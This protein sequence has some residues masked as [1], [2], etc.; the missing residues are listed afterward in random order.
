MIGIWPALPHVV[1]G[2]ARA[3]AGSAV[4]VH[5]GSHAVFGNSGVVR[6]Q[7]GARG[8]SSQARQR[9]GAQAKGVAAT[10]TGPRDVGFRDRHT[11]PRAQFGLCGSVRGAPTADEAQ[12][13]EVSTPTFVAV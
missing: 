13:A 5:R 3:V 10:A 8:G 11:A 6:G 1:V 2:R 4:A 7:S 9:G 12:T